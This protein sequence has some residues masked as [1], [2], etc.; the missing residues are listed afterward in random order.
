MHRG[1]FIYAE[2]WRNRLHPELE[3]HRRWWYGDSPVRKAYLGLCNLIS[4]PA[5]EAWKTN[6]TLANSGWTAALLK[7]QFGVESRVVYP[8]VAGSFPPVEW[9]Q[10]ENGFVCVGR[11]VPEKRMDAVIRILE[12]VREAGHDVHLHILGGLDDSHF[13]AGS[14]GS[15][16]SRAATG[17]RW[18]AA[19]CGAEERRYDRRAIASALTAVKMNPSASPPRKW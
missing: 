4:A 12:K 1:L 15:W 18:K 2:E 3:N 17:S 8:P 5:S 13:G 11:V 6:L 19:P 9:E 10:Q 14:S 7:E 16:P